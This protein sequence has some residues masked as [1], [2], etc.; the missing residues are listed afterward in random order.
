MTSPKEAIHQNYDFLLYIKFDT[1]IDKQTALKKL[2]DDTSA[3]VKEEMQR[4]K[5]IYE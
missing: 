1:A 2:T 3:L 4:L 5:N